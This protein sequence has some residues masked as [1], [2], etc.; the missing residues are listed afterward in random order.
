MEPET[1]DEGPDLE[2]LFGVPEEVRN[3]VTLAYLRPYAIRALWQLLMDPEAPARYRMDAIKLVIERTKEGAGQD[4]EMGN[5]AQE[6]EDL[7]ESL[8]RRG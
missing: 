2:A 6:V 4:A 3:S 5:V 7:V 8:R 1:P